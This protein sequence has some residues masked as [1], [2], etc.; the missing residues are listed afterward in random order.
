MFLFLPSCDYYFYTYVVLIKTMVAG[1]IKTVA[2]TNF[3]TARLEKILENG[4][5]VVSNQ[6]IFRISDSTFLLN[7]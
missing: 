4:I 6:V 1:K 3:D 2:L 5:P 7:L